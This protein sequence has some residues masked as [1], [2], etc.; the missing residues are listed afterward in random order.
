MFSDISI[1]GSRNGKVV[2]IKP[3]NQISL[4]LSNIKFTTTT[5][6]LIHHIGAA[7]V[8]CLSLCV[9]NQPMLKVSSIKMSFE[10]ILSF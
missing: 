7:S 5:V 10:L 4:C 3:C 8:C 9:K 1:I 6:D 2:V